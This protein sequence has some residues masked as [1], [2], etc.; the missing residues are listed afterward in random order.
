MDVVVN[1][2]TVYPAIWYESRENKSH[3][4]Q[5]SFI[6]VF[7]LRENRRRGTDGHTDGRGAALN[8]PPRAPHKNY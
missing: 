4:H 5:S 8:A 7:L 1:G 6:F 2:T 3:Y